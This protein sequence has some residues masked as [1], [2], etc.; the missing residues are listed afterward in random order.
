M[1]AK[2]AEVTSEI[3][4]VRRRTDDHTA[5]RAYFGAP[6]EAF[7]AL[8]GR[9]RA[10]SRRARV[11][12]SRRRVPRRAL[13][14]DELETSAA[15]WRR[16]VSVSSDVARARCGSR[17]SAK[18]VSPS[19]R[20]LEPPSTGRSRRRAVG[21]SGR[22]RRCST[23]FATGERRADEPERRR[24][25]GCPRR[26]PPSAC[27]R[28][29]GRIQAFLSLMSAATPG[30]RRTVR[31]RRDGDRRDEARAQKARAHRGFAQQADQARRVP[32]TAA[33][34]AAPGVELVDERRHRQRR[35]VGARFRDADAQVLAHPVDGEAEIELVGDHRLAAVLHLPRLRRALADHVE[36]AQRRR[37]RPSRAKLM[38]S[39]ERLHQPRDADL[40][41]HLRE[42]AAA[43][44]RPS[45]SPRARS[46]RARLPRARTRRRRRRP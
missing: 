3:A 41:D 31:Q 25:C 30:R 43:G 42:L 35:A 32:A 11:R 39:D 18:R 44:T 2:T 33:L 26:R 36:H 19:A 7:A 9:R 28:A 6:A 8:L 22:P 37:A 45:A 23:D 17:C 4:I 13:S 34:R 16:A 27:P 20:D 5:R 14:L 24:R 21:S 15:R 12:R 38:P 46:A 1:L 29:C 40:V 10:G